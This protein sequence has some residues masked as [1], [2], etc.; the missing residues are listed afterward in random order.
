MMRC[1]VGAYPIDR[2]CF[3][4][5]MAHKSRHPAVQTL[6][7]VLVSRDLQDA[8][9]ALLST[10]RCL[11]EVVEELLSCPHASTALSSSINL[12]SRVIST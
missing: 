4:S 6:T 9:N 12:K 7:F 8:S 11:P 5:N 1:H 2:M 10:G 3:E